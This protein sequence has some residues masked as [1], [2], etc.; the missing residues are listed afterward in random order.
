MFD[1]TIY[2]F[3]SELIQSVIQ[4]ALGFFASRPL[5]SLPPPLRFLGSGVYALYYQ[6]NL[7]LYSKISEKNHTA[8]IEEKIPIYVGKAVPSGWRTARVRQTEDASIYRRLSEH[9]NTITACE[10]LELKDF[11][12]KFLI[13]NEIEGDLI[14]PI[15]AA[16]I[17]HYTPLWNSFID[18]FGNHDPGSGRYNQ[19]MSEW[20]TFHPGRSWA[21]KCAGKE[22]QIDHITEKIRDYCD[23]L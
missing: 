20:D 22:P 12:C 1:H 6:G 11:Q 15:E 5:T 10:N 16:L 13:L 7:G 18:G 14:V 23:S 17:R 2:I 3:K 4:N 19:S 21:K 8:N 9:S